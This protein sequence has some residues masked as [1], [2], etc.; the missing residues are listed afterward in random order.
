LE[1]EDA[2]RKMGA[3]GPTK[4]RQLFSKE[5]ML[6]GIERIYSRLLTPPDESEP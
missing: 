3:A 6:E 1:D 5:I 2:R 4:A